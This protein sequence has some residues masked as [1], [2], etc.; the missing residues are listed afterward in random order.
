MLDDLKMMANRDKSDAFGVAEK[1]PGQ[2]RH[3]IGAELSLDREIQNVVLS[4]MGGSALAANL[5]L[6]WTT[7]PFPFVID[8]TYD[9]PGFTGPNTL[10]IV[11][12]YSG[13]TE[14]ELSALAQA[15]D[16]GAMIV[17]MTSG[18]RLADI[19]REKSYPL[20]LIP[21]GIQPR[22]SVFYQ[23]RALAEL[24]DAM[25]LIL[26]LVPQL[27]TSADFL[28][29][30]VANW[31]PDVPTS[32]NVAKE[33]AE[34]LMGKTPVVYAG[35]RLSSAAYKWKISFNESSKN[36]A[37]FNQFSEFNH[38]EFLG[39][40]GHPV[41]KPFQPI[42]LMSSFEHPQIKQRFAASN[43]L[44]SGQMP[45]P[46]QIEAEGNTLIEQILWMVLLGDF[47]SL[48]LAMLNNVDPTPVDLI[49]KLKKELA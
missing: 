28:E 38:N 17:V 12:S 9:V 31:R 15:A 13:N 5:F 35:P 23:L 34:E 29:E 27:E 14:E 45:H 44:L 41:E 21:T 24:M 16:K 39:W 1:E 8:R 42:E 33:L 22:M 48:Y 2:L 19:A 46:L 43:K 32:K 36:M 18:G 20:L 10:F 49:E 6:S 25:G 4:G 7:P 30:A 47:V 37:F 40:T 26:D 11:S 3:H